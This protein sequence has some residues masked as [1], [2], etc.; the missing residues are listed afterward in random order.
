MANPQIAAL[1]LQIAALNEQIVALQADDAADDAQIAS[2]QAQV[3]ALQDQVVALTEND[4]SDAAQI[5]ALT[6]QV[7]ALTAQNDALQ[8]QIENMTQDNLLDLGS[9]NITI[10][11]QGENA[12]EAKFDLPSG[13]SVTKQFPPSG[14]LTMNL[15]LGLGLTH[16]RTQGGG[17]G[18]GAPEWVP[19]GALIHIDLVRAFNAQDAA[20]VDGTGV[21]AV[22]TL[23]GA[24]VNADAYWGDT[25]AYSSEDLG[26]TGLIPATF[27][28]FIGAARTLLTTETGVSVVLGLAN[29]GTTGDGELFI[30]SA[31]GNS[32]MKVTI[33]GGA[34]G[35]ASVISDLPGADDF[36]TGNIGIDPFDTNDTCKV[37]FTIAQPVSTGAVCANGGVANTDS[38]DAEDWP[39]EGEEF[40][41]A[42]YA[43][44]EIAL[45]SVTIYAPVS[46]AA[47]SPLT[48]L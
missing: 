22:D 42:A 10:T 17:G 15:G 29:A 39:G 48:T 30:S 16:V 5:A 33:G 9:M 31:S 3:A 4:E 25:S 12:T 32:A 7:A 46:A 43:T 41:A 26:A 18:G 36:F 11:T 38:I 47:L 44:A 2:L 27:V 21:V 28:A 13:V 34:P 6:A 1:Q 20:Y 45:V 14:E 24:D 8:Q 37:G 40:V 19:E 35:T 23:L